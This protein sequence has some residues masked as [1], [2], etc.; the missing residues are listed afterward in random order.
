M[1]TA[2]PLY[3]AAYALTALSVLVEPSIYQRIFAAKNTRTIR[4]A[5]FA[6]IFIWAA[7]D[8]G[9]TAIGMVG[10]TLQARGT[11][12]MD[13]PPDQLL[14]QVVLL[15]LPIGLSGLFLSGCLAAAMSTIDSYLLVSSGN[16]IYDMYR[17]IFKPNET[18]DNLIRY[19]RISIFFSSVICILVGLYFETI[20]QAWIFMATLLTSTIFLPV[21]AALFSSSEKKSLQGTLSTIG[22]LS[23][24]ILFFV[25]MGI[26]GEPEPDLETY[27]MSIFNVTILQEYAL[28]FSLPISA[29]GFWIGGMIR[30]KT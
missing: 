18:D 26:W 16:L 20:K 15:Y 9:V 3:T 27:K 1:G 21:L 4:I 12:S 22:G 30:R 10:G 8:W 23:A 14:L 25:A 11:L 24:C 13:V 7:Y 29:L 5:F 6:G 28:F 19:T 17:P 2:P